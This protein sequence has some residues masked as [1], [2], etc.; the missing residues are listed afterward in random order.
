MPQPI[1]VNQDTDKHICQFILSPFHQF[2]WKYYRQ[3][4]NLSIEEPSTKVKNRLSYLQ[5]LKT[6]NPS[7]FYAHCKKH[8]LSFTEKGS[9]SSFSSSSEEEISSSEEESDDD[10]DRLIPSTTSRRQPNLPTPTRRRQNLPTARTMAPYNP[11][12][13]GN[14][15]GIQMVVDLG[16]HLFGVVVWTDVRLEAGEVMINPDNGAEVM[17]RKL[18]PSASLESASEF[19][20]RFSVEGSKEFDFANDSENHVTVKFQEVF[21]ECSKDE[22][23]MKEEDKYETKVLIKLPEEMKQSFF[24]RKGN[25]TNE[26]FNG[27]DAHGQQIVA[28][29]VKSARYVDKPK[30]ATL[31]TAGS[32]NAMD[33]SSTVELEKMMEKMKARSEE[34]EKLSAEKEAAQREAREAMEILRQQQEAAQVREQEY[35]KFSQQTEQRFKQDYL[36]REQAARQQMEQEFANRLAAFQQEQEMKRK[37][38]EDHCIEVMNQYLKGQAAGYGPM[39][40]DVDGDSFDA[41]HDGVSSV[42]DGVYSAP[43]MEGLD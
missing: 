26:V 2:G 19:L 41:D 25:E 31:K 4:Y 20:T 32:P 23:N 11:K 16:K 13:T 28:F 17:C 3:R 36:A 12:I 8:N 15:F 5:R 10:F 43:G 7:A 22:K 34:A 42:P 39:P 27:V 38:Y 33:A 24:D 37:E 30:A 29:F 9:N 14:K 6:S 21:D 1:Q 40:Q 18:K 35:Q